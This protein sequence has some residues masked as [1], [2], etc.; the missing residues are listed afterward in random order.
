MN[1][2][3][4]WVFHGLGGAMVCPFVQTV[5]GCVWTRNWWLSPVTTSCAP[6]PASWMAW[7]PGNGKS[8]MRPSRGIWGWEM[9]VK[10]FFLF[11]SPLVS[12]GFFHFKLFMFDLYIVLP[13]GHGSNR[14]GQKSNWSIGNFRF[15]MGFVGQKA[16]KALSWSMGDFSF[17]DVFGCSDL[18]QSLL[19]S[20]V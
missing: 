7:S 2:S 17:W 13:H 12:S 19:Y 14:M 16:L 6:S 3:K 5:F 10:L 4:P 11:C 20:H 15:W 18:G 9:G 1:T 8:S